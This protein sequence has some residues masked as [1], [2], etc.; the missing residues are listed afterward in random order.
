MYIEDYY[1][2]AT[3]C[4]IYAADTRFW[5]ITQGVMQTAFEKGIIYITTKDNV[6]IPYTIIFHNDGKIE[7]MVNSD[8]R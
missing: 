2:R 1:D 3:P 5:T 7:I 4:A 6:I 8:E